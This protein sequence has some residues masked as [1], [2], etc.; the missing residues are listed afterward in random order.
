MTTVLALTGNQIAWS[1]TL[2]VGLVVVVVV[3]LLL[4]ALR[5]TVLEVEEA[6]SDA[7]E[8][9]RRVENNTITSYLLKATRERGGELVQELEHHR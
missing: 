8:A 7:W 4:E 3:A 6:A 1:I 9:G 5:K 2:V